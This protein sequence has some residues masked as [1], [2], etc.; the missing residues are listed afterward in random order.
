MFPLSWTDSWRPKFPW[1]IAN[2]MEFSEPLI[3]PPAPC[4]ELQ[5]LRERIS[6]RDE[7]IANLKHLE[8]TIRRNNRLF[9][10]LIAAS[11]DGIA[12][13]RPDA[14][15]IRVVK[16]ILGYGPGTLSGMSVYDAIHADD[17]EAMRE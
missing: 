14:T 2:F 13:T 3:A 6:E 1:T 10:A 12:L 8:G 9:E 4:G 17:H 5:S 16:S 7:Q 11:Q 15:I